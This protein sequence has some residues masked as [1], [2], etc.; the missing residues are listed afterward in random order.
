MF[1]YISIPTCDVLESE[2]MTMAD[3]LQP[4]RSIDEMF[5]AEFFEEHL[6]Y[7]GGSRREEPHEAGGSCR[8]QPQ[9]T[10]N[11]AGF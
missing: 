4:R 3:R 6:G 10:A 1:D 9:C 11:I 2:A 8:N 5:L 7:C